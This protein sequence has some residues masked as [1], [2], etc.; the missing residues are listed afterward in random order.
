MDPNENLAAWRRITSS[1]GAFLLG[2]RADGSL[3]TDWPD[4]MGRPW[5]S[6][7]SFDP[8]CLPQLADLLHRYFAGEAVDPARTEF[9]APTGPPFYRS[10]WDA[11]RT[12]P[13]GS[14]NSY[15]DLARRAG[16]PRAL[17]AAGGSMRSNPMPILIPC[18]R[19]IASN[20]QLGG[21]AGHRD[22]DSP[23]LRLKRT[24]LA[25]E[26]ASTAPIDATPCKDLLPCT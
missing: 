17:R 5:P 1:L 19:V 22:L 13:P 21:F 10:C 4:C 3:V 20:G 25:M 15:A 23:A 16:N 18:H 14:T 9:P 8:R 6:R 26:T 11:C 2:C 7:S 12:I 24:L